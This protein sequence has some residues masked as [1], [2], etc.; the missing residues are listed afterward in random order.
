MVLKTKINHTNKIVK[1]IFYCISQVRVP[2]R[3]RC[4]SQQLIV[5]LKLFQ[6]ARHCILIYFKPVCL[7]VTMASKTVIRPIEFFLHMAVVIH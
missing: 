7:L 3:K 1:V 5:E 4:G 6:L 2:C